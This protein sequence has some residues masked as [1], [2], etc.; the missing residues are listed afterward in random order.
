MWGLSYRLMDISRT[1]NGEMTPD[2]P[3]GDKWAYPFQQ[4]ATIIKQK[5]NEVRDL[6]H[7]RRRTVM[8]AM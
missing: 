8:L 3:V 5:H 4:P 2:Q 7:T 1:S 6:E